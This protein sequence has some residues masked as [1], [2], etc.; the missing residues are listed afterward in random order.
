MKSIKVFIQV[1]LFLLLT[2]SINSQCVRRILPTDLGFDSGG[3]SQTFQI[4]AG[5]C[6]WSFI[7]DYDWLQFSALEGFSGTIITV[8]CNENFGESK[9]AIITIDT[10]VLTITQEAFVTPIPEEP[11]ITASNCGS[12][13]LTRTTPPPNVKWYWQTIS[14]GTDTTNSGENYVV[15]A[16]SDYYLRARSSGEIWSTSSVSISVDV[17]DIPLLGEISGDAEHCKGATASFSIVPVTGATSYIWEAPG[18]EYTA[19]DVTSISYPINFSGTLSVQASNTCGTAT[20]T[21]SLNVIDATPVITPENVSIDPGSSVNLTQSGATTYSWNPSSNLSFNGSIV[22]AS[23]LETTTY[24]VTGTTNQCSESIDY[25]L[26][27]NLQ[28]SISY[29]NSVLTATAS[30]GKTP[31]TYYWEGGFTGNTH[32]PGINGA[33]TVTVTGALGQTA[34]ATY[35]VTDIGGFGND[36]LDPSQG[37]LKSAYNF[38]PTGDIKYIRVIIH[39]LLKDDGTGNFNEINDGLI[40][41]NDFNGYDYAEYIVNFMNTHLSYPH[42]MNLQPFGSIPVYDPEYRFEI[43]GVYFWRSTANYHAGLTTLMNTYGKN[44]T[45]CLNLFLLNYEE[46]SAD[47]YVRYLGDNAIVSNIHYGNYKR[48]LEGTDPWTPNHIAQLIINHE[49]GHCLNLHHTLMT[50]DGVCS[51]THTDYCDDTPTIQDMLDIN[52]PNPCCWDAGGS[53]TCSNN[54]MDYNSDGKA[55]TPDQLDRVHEELNNDKWYF[56]RRHFMTPQIDIGTVTSSNTYIAA[57]VTLSKNT[58]TTISNGTAVF[59]NADEIEFHEG[60]TMN[61]GLLTVIV[62]D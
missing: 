57:K 52:E 28:V 31:Y 22:T 61:N 16:S 36:V 3:G 58:N 17:M 7:D 30:G 24:H 25:N 9:T 1:T 5:R 34:S 15:T 18:N 42:S 40:P 4:T 10:M 6:S 60:F 11:T 29:S 2:Q 32:T 38:T 49:I 56:W 48:S 21:K 54:L 50:S 45:E 41:A 62:K 20:S 43:V 44:T 23:P 59:I 47:G 39:Y 27:V 55:I 53:F 33:Y 14:N 13:T 12:S 46:H 19:T 26:T 37:N 35:N 8:D 51:L